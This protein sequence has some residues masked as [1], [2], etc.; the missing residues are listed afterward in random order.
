MHLF[1]IILNTMSAQDT[2]D[3]A[4][5]S[6]A[7]RD[8]YQNQA[9]GREKGMIDNVCMTLTG[10]IFDDLLLCESEFNNNYIPRDVNLLTETTPVGVAVSQTTHAG[11]MSAKEAGEQEMLSGLCCA[12]HRACPTQQEWCP[13]EGY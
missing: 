10:L 13:V 6:S 4:S 1:K 8:I 3:H 7:L 9:V 12:G 5:L 11:T 2:A